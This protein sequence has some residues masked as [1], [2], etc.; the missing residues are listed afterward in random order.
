[1]VLVS[2]IEPSFKNLSFRC[3]TVIDEVFLDIQ[4]EYDFVH[5]YGGEVEWKINYK[6]SP[7]PLVTWFDNHG[8]QIAWTATNVENVKFVATKGNLTSKLR[9]RN[10]T[11]DDS[12]NYTFYADNGHQTKQKIFQLSVEGRTNH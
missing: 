2:L 3:S 8:N 4:K 7:T 6:G 9:I 5:S 11:F 1:M 12:G 10:L